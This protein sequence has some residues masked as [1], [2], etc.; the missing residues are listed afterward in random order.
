MEGTIS[1]DTFLKKIEFKKY[2]YFDLWENFEPI[3]EFS[4][5]H[6]IPIYAVES[7]EAEDQGLEQR[8]KKAGEI[9]ADILE[10]HP[11]Q[12]L[13]VFVGDLHIAPDHLPR[14]VERNLAKRGLKRKRLI[15][16]QNS[17]AIYWKLAEQKREEKVEIVK[18]N[19]ESY[20]L[21]NTPPIVWQQT[22]LNWLEHEGES[23][24]YV[25]AKHT[26]LEIVERIADFLEL[27]LPKDYDEM[28]T[29][30]CGDLSFL[31]AL[32]KDK[33]FTAKELKAIRHQIL[34]SESY[35]IPRTR[36]I[37]LAN[38]SINHAAEEATH[39]L[40]YLCSGNEIE[41]SL[42][43]AFYANTIHEAIGFLGSKIINHKRKC[44]H[45]RQVKELAEYLS[46]IHIPSHRRIEL[47][48]ACLVLEHKKLERRKHPTPYR[49]TIPHKTEV[50]LGATHIL[51]YMLGDRLYHSL[52]SGIISKQE[53]R[54]LFTSRMD[55]EDEPFNI[56]TKLVRKTK[57]VRLPR[58][59]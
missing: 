36:F 59:L 13:F 40:K 29:F 21:I 39:Y 19:N 23:I 41:R 28:E 16:Y 45:E 10:K 56:Y 14:H 33:S 58:R 42:T 55:E 31:E 27:R 37:Y 20:C 48:I 25:D 24:D 8:D 53:I 11:E 2:W 12:K 50:F 26:I 18:I 17:E 5:Y 34:S 49:E 3:F 35:F 57:K 7:A 47:E 54:E 6:S 22:F 15:L 43:D 38:V 1:K 52:V 4:R 46:S 32:K 30:T 44:L 9:I 51:G